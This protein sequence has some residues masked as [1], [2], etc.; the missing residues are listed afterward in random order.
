MKIACPACGSAG[1][2]PALRD[3]PDDGLS[4]FSP[5]SCKA[6]GTEFVVDLDAGDVPKALPGDEPLPIP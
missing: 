3:C 1:P 5:Y 6:C 4:R 2:H